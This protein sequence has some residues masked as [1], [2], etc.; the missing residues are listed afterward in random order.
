MRIL[1]LLLVLSIQVLS[2]SPWGDLTSASV[3]DA[4]C[5]G[6]SLSSGD[7]DISTLRRHQAGKTCFLT[8]GIVFYDDPGPGLEP[9]RDVFAAP[10]VVPVAI[11]I[12]SP[13]V[14]VL[15]C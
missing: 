7:D 11:P 2:L 12:A 13:P 15:R 8:C 10:A 1:V 4:P 6:E 9:A 5:M 3:P 14:S